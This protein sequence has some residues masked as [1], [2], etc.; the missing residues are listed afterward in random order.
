M[1]QDIFQRIKDAYPIV[2]QVAHRTPLTRSNTFSRMTGS[3]IFLKLECLQRT[4][5][6]KIRGATYAISQFKSSEKEQGCVAA[7]AG[8]HAQ[9]VA[10]AAAT[11][12]IKSIIVMPELAPASKIIATQ[13]YGAEV[14]LHGMNYDDAVIKAEQISVETGAVFLHSFDNINVIAGQGT[15]GLELIEDL[16]SLDVVLVP[17]GGGGLISGISIAFKKIRPDTKIIG[18]QASGCP[19]MVESIRKGRITEIAKSDTIA[20]GIAVRK[21]SETTLKVVN[22]LLDDVITVS[23]DEISHSIF[24]LLERSKL[25]I[26]PAGAVGLA[27]LLNNKINVVG[28][29]VGVV[30][31]GGNIDMSL[32]ERII[33][34]SLYLE[35]RFVRI[36]GL[37]PDKRETL[38]DLL[39]VIATTKASVVSIEHERADPNI[40]L[41]RMNVTITLEVS[42]KR[43]LRELMNNLGKAGYKFRVVK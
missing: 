35:S 17:V 32:L 9:G 20:D 42:Q 43:Y 25:V 39:L 36:T 5:S 30:L 22:E 13:G 6:F 24:M 28:K 41:G 33:E 27:A 31:S 12:G 16:P 18:V 7:S 11:A 40:P 37:L 26:E 2:Q 1:F 14:I 4:G 21:P 23:D 8:N 15:I 10:Y 3:E 29:K 19:S 38:K 34:R